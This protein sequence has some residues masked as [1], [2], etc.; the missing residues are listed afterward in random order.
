LETQAAPNIL[1]VDDEKNMRFLLREALAKEGYV[2]DTA[3]NGED[4]VSLVKARPFDCVLLDLRMPRMD[5]IATLEELNRI[6]PETPVIIM[7]AFGSKETAMNAI[8]LGAYD[9]FTKPFDIDEM[10]IVVKRALE[11]QKLE[12]EIRKLR[13]CLEIRGAFKGII[14]QSREMVEVFDLVSKVVKNDVTVIIYGESG[15]G[16]E[17]IANVIHEQ[18][19]RRDSPMVKINC[20]AIPETLLESELFGFEKGSFTGALQR[21]I[22]KFE[23]ANHGTLFLDEIGDMSLVTQAKLLRV[24][25]E[26]K[27][28]RIGGNESIDVDIRIIAATNQD[29]SKAVHE[30]SFRE[31]LYFRLNVVPIFLPPLRARKGDIP[32][33]IDYFIDENNTKLSRE[34]CGVSRNAM[35]LLLAYDWPGNV[36]ELENVIQ[37]AVLLSSQDIIGEDCLPTSV[38]DSAP[39]TPRVGGPPTAFDGSLQE[40]VENIAAS[41][42]RQIII[43]ALERTNWSRTKT[44]ELLKICRKSLHNKMKKHGLFDEQKT[45]DGFD[46]D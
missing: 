19:P 1:I 9:Y 4:A 24:L 38:T 28:E 21:K 17:L 8:S 32:L 45:P 22:G 41:A 31:D 20:A 3:E 30:K 14:G 33:L 10:R 18:G 26:R 2:I 43:D 13:G 16:K 46:A 15:T 27:I 36:R 39:Q 29:L 6:T 12:E 23:Y 7:T 37:R 44:A 35:R 5:G 40:I 34:I 42:E 11:K 25:E